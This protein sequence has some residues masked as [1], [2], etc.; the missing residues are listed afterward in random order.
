MIKSSFRF[1]VILIIDFHS[2]KNKCRCKF[3]EQCK[4]ENKEFGEGLICELE[5]MS[6]IS[7]QITTIYPRISNIKHELKPLTTCPYCGKELIIED[8]MES[9]RRVIN[10]LC[11]NQ[12]CYG[13]LSQ[14]CCDFLKQ[15]GHK[16]ISSTTLENMKYKYF[17]K[18]YDEKLIK[19]YHEVGKKEKII[20]SAKS[21]NKNKP[22]LYF[23]DIME[24]MNVKTFLISTSLFTKA[25]VSSFI[26]SLGL[27]EMDNLISVLHTEKYKKLVD[28]LLNK[29]N[30]FINDLTKF[31]LSHYCHVKQDK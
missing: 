12:K 30:F 26:N 24:T 6:D 20:Y 21:V 8:K 15:I 27:N 29:T 18:L 14:K 4:T 11:V 7:P 25:K 31:I 2:I 10:V 13:L 1:L 16:G 23:D 9:K 5:L 22:K 17:S 19:E 3:T 28:Y